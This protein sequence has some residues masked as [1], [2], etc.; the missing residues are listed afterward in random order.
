MYFVAVFLSS[1]HSLLVFGQGHSKILS[2]SF[3]VIPLSP[4]SLSLLAHYKCSMTDSALL[5]HPQI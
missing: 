4:T 3:S 2:A 1:L 5:P